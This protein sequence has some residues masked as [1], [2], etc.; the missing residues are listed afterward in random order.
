MSVST[1]KDTVCPLGSPI[2]LQNCHSPVI[3]FAEN[4][5]SCFSDFHNVYVFEEK[6]TSSNGPLSNQNCIFFLYRTGEVLFQ[7]TFLLQLGFL[8]SKLREIGAGFRLGKGVEG[9]SSSSVANNNFICIT[10]EVHPHCSQTERLKY[11]L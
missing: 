4:I 6:K 8:Y 10:A 3:F 9:W 11:T 1:A 2:I 7:S 5:F